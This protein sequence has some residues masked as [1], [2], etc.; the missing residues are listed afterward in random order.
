MAF[1]EREMN[2]VNTAQLSKSGAEQREC[3]IQEERV[4][5]IPNSRTQKTLNER[6]LLA[7]KATVHSS[8]NSSGSNGG[9]DGTD[10][11]PTPNGS[12]RELK[13]TS[14]SSGIERNPFRAGTCCRRR[15]T[16]END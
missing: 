8:S 10:T 5:Y 15:G 7:T 6:A 14:G 13:L 16:M 3:I 12:V 11:P 9:I 2:T 1:Y 4:T